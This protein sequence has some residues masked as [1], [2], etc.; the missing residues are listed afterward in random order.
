[1]AENA[2]SLEGFACGWERR[3]AEAWSKA[4]ERR[5]LLYSSSVLEG[6]KDALNAVEIVQ[7]MKNSKHV[8]L[9][10]SGK[11]GLC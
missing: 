11:V 8:R 6:E 3:Q 5:K 9:H 1:L 4:V 2:L 10:L 7:R